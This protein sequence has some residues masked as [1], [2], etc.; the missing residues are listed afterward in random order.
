M[1]TG[2]IS[3]LNTQQLPAACQGFCLPGMAVHGRKP[4]VKHRLFA[5]L[6]KIQIKG[7]KWSA[8]VADT[9]T[10]PGDGHHLGLCVIGENGV[11][12]ALI[13]GSKEPIM[14]P[15]PEIAIGKPVKAPAAVGEST[16]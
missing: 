2:Q 10:I 8:G 13:Q 9:G 12:G 5:A 7:R 15:L 4:A 6:G 14:L 11:A 16:K 1:I 3:C